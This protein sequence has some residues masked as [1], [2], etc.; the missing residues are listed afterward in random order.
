MAADLFGSLPHGWNVSV[1]WHQDNYP[2]VT[3]TLTQDFGRVRRDANGHGASLETAF[4][5]AVDEMLALLASDEESA[6]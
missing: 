2:C 3:L 6:Q 1:Q 5:M 4:K